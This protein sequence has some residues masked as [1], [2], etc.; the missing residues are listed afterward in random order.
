MT[1]RTKTIREKVIVINT[2]GTISMELDEGTDAVSVGNEQPLHRLEPLI[3]QYANTEM[4]DLFQVPSPYMT[5]Q[6]MEELAAATRQHLA[7]DDVLGV[8]ITHGTDTL[9]ETAYYLDLTVQSDKPVVVTGAMR[10]SNEVGA[11]GPVNLLESIRVAADKRSRGRGTLVVFN[12]EIHAA[13]FVTKT[14]TSNVSTFQSPSYGPIG[15]V[16]ARTASYHQPPS[17]SRAY[18]IKESSPARIPLVKMVAGQ[19]AAWLQW[20]VTSDI[21][22]VIIEAFG[23]GNV[24]PAVVPVIEQLCKKGLPVV[25]VSR[26]YNGYVQDVYGYE[27]G[28][29][30]LRELGCIFSNGLNG[31][32]AR[33][34]LLVLCGAGVTTQDMQSHFAY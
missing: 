22:G 11:D 24:P 33:I 28:G 5:P 8:V 1:E 19:E 10:S 27:G 18:Q 31:Q 15:F 4:V 3:N 32:K 14:H 2:G 23:A 30:Q 9:E 7:D 20:L 13:R 6:M 29:K 21:D 17:R 16:T 34:R 26:C 25:I 12:D